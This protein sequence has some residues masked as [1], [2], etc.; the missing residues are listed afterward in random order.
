MGDGLSDI[1]QHGIHTDAIITPGGTGALYMSARNLLAPG[2]AVLL[3][4]LH[5]GLTTRFA[6]S[7][8]LPQRLGP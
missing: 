7:V 8:V 1:Q 6:T 4:E 2:D 3:R 5:W